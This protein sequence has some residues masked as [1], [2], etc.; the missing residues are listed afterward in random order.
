MS[1]R[2]SEKIWVLALF[3][4]I[5]GLLAAL[6]LGVTSRLTA[7]PI[8]QSVLRNEL[9]MLKEL[10]L[11]EFDNDM[12]A[13][14]F[15]VNGVEYMAAR[16]QGK[17]VGFAARSQ[18]NAGY[19]GLLKSLVSFDVNGN[20]LAVQV[21]EHKETPGLGATVCERKFQ[22]TLFNIFDEVPNGLPPN[23]ILDQFRGKN[24][25]DSGNWKIIKDGGIFT[26]RTGATVTSRAVMAMVNSA[27]ADFDKAKAY[28]A[29]G[30]VK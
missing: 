25:S 11:P 19:S 28:F 13:D 6:V 7:E 14:V 21:V 9:K 24:A 5:T 15:T 1:I 17:I 18:S 26:Y 29:Q 20:I 16:N 23:A 4:G 22:K 27:A 3:L 30:A 2:N 12:T 8:R 10:D